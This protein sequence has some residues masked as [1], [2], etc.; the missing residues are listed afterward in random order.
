MTYVQEIV[1][2]ALLECAHDGTVPGDDCLLNSLEALRMQRKSAAKP[3]ESLEERES[4]GFCR[5]GN[6]DQ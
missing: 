3:G 1:V 4:V 2:N 6:G 5:S